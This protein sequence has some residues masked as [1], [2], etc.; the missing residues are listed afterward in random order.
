MDLSEPVLDHSG[1]VVSLSEPRV[2]A[3]QWSESWGLTTSALGGGAKPGTLTCSQTN[4]MLC[5]TLNVFSHV[6]TRGIEDVG[7]TQ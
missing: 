3:M 4:A 2:T 1:P 5:R 6:T 7:A